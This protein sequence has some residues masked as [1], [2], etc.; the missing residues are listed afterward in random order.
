MERAPYTPGPGGDA[1]PGARGPGSRLL[2]FTLTIPFPS[3]MDA[4]IAH[5]FLTPNE[6]LQEP[7]R[8]ELNVNGS[9]LTVRLTADDPGRLQMSI[10]SCLG[11][12]SLVIRTMQIIMPPFFTKPQQ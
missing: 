12:L 3:A 1:A 2:Q 9:I 11:Q 8:E 5:R 10:T 7:V 4:E 6:E